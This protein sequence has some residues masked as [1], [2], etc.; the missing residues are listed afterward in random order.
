MTT[1]QHILTGGTILTMDPA[2]PTA[3]AVALAEGRILAVGRQA[4]ILALAGPNTLREDLR[5]NTLLP[6]LIE[7]HTHALWGACRDLYQVY[8]GYQASLSQL[9]QA[10]A[11]RAA[12]LAPGTWIAGGP[13]RLD[14]Q[15]SLPDTPRAWLDAIAPAHP[16][17][18]ADTTQHA[19]WCNSAALAQAGLAD[20]CAP[21][22][23]GVVGQ[24]GPEGRLT[25]FL[26]EAAC[27]PVRAQTGFTPAQLDAAC[28]QAVGYFNSLG[29][30]GFKEP[31]A[32]AEDLGA[33]A[34]AYDRGALSLH[35]AAH[36][37]AF[38]PLS[39]S[40]MPLAEIDALVAR[41]GRTGLNLRFTKL[42]LDGV[43]PALTASF[44]APYLPRPGYDPAHHS[45][46]ATLL[47]PPE[48]LNQL[49]T[50]HDAAGYTVKMHAVGDN[51][52]R[53]GLD[54][55]AAAR[56]ANGPAGPRHEIAH[57][58]FI[59]DADLPRF[60]ALNAVAEVSPKLWM[61]NA[62][63]AAQRAV[64]GQ[65]RLSQVHRIR[66][67]LQAGAEVIFG[68]DWPAAAPDA[69]PWSG[70]AG[71]ISRADPSGVF[72]GQVAP[73]QAISLAQALPLFTRNAARA[74]GLEGETGMLRA[75][76]SADFI[77]VPGTLT[78]MSTADIAATLP[79]RTV[80]KGAAVFEG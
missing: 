31:S 73:D 8:V 64:L 60:A 50:A 15:D 11:A 10:I 76:L 30:T 28:A 42:F 55:I 67:L 35:A 77:I 53:R 38:S 5:G 29:Y 17:A 51:A 70:L 40:T 43:A 58:T 69:N 24:E 3:E 56:Q 16:V 44:L 68:T 78:E 75:G 22:P 54:A 20:G 4:D 63:T 37:A 47:L 18:I 1:A 2:Q 45:P 23:G 59:D 65:A 48:Q 7:S 9:A 52:A 21:I 66:S 12:T 33:Y 71:M 26:A 6:G 41:F 39:G 61:P 14:M 27:G 57:S 13:W 62:A 32:Q 74:M 19:M 72:P 25:G 79:V 46:D 80:F 36:I 34:R 49:V